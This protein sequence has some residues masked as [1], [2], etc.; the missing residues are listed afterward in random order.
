ME[1]LA[2]PKQSPVKDLPLSLSSSLHAD[3]D[4]I[5]YCSEFLDQEQVEYRAIGFGQCGTVFERP[6]RGFVFKVAKSS[7]EDSLWADFKA[8]FFVRQAFEQQKVTEKSIECRVPRVFSY[9]RIRLN[10]SYDSD[11]PAHPP[12]PKLARNILIKTYCPDISRKRVAAHP[13]NRDCLARVYLGRRRTTT[14]P[15]ANFTLRNFNLHLDQMIELGIPVIDLAIDIGEA[16]AVVHWS[17]HVDGYDIEFVLGSEESMEYTGD[18]CLT[19]KLT[20]AQ[21]AAM[22]PHTDIESLM[23]FDFE[24]RTT[25]LW[26]LDFNLCNIWRN[27]LL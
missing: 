15:S 25:R 13:T 26:I 22:S 8:H 5:T 1:H 10:T 4:W 19:R 16:L 11:H 27:Q 23:P 3:M 2:K 7:Y 12:L 21:L 6:G 17:A 18:L 24:P 20:R 9:A 14:A